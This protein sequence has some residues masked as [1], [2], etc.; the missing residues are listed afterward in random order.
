MKVIIFGIS[1]VG[2]RHYGSS[3]LV[4]GEAYLLRRD[5]HN[6]HDANAVAVVERAPGH[7]K[8][9]SVQRGHAAIIAGLFDHRPKLIRDDTVYIK[10]KGLPHYH[11]R[12]SGFAQR[13]NVGFYLSSSDRQEVERLLSG[14]GLRFQFS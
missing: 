1:A 3:S 8:R 5:R 12:R 9:A 4:V 14:S 7:R 2:M 10:P 13:C 6:P 11:S